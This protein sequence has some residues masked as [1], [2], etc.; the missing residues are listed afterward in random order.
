MQATEKRIDEKIAKLDTLQKS[1]DASLKVQDDRDEARLQSLAHMYEQ[2]KPAE[3]SRI[4]DQLDVPVILTMLTHM[5]EM[6]AAP[7]LATMDPGKAKL[8][9]LALAEHRKSPTAP[10]SADDAKPSN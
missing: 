8:V 4:L 2:M 9:T 7:I 10:P 1:I 6:K 5:R 3:A